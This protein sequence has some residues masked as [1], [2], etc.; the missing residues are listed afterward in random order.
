MSS[1][2]SSG[3]RGQTII[4]ADVIGSAADFAAAKRLIAAGTPTERRLLADP[5][6]PLKSFAQRP[7]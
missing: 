7:R 2:R 1:G 3:I 6:V 5:A 4:A